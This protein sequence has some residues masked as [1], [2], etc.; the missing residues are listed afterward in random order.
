VRQNQL[1]EAAQSSGCELRRTKPAQPREA[2][3]GT[4]AA[5]PGFY[6]EALPDE[7]LD[8]ALRRGLIV[9]PY[10]YGIARE[11]AEQLR[12]LQTVVPTG[13]IVAPGGAASPYE[14]A[15]AAYRRAA[16]LHEVHGCGDRRDQ[17]LRGRYSGTG[18]DR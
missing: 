7:R 3:A 16:R 18:A 10:R 5:R 1:V 6:D 2:T 17:A 13:T 8:V 9:I 12:V 11:R 4:V 14:V 15:V